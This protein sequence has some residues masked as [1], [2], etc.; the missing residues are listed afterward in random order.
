MRRAS[1]GGGA[2]A[3]PPAQNTILATYFARAR[4]PSTVRKLEPAL[5]VPG[6]ARTVA[7]G[8]LPTHAASGSG[9]PPAPGPDLGGT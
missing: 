1:V 4:E 5:R 6:G 7:A 2:A 3:A 8:A 9:A